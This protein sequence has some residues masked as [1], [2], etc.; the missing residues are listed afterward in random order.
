MTAQFS[1][2][3][4]KLINGIKK[5]IYLNQP[6]QITIN[7]LR[8]TFKSA[9]PYRM[10]EYSGSLASNS[11]QEEKIFT[12]SP[13]SA[14]EIIERVDKEEKVIISANDKSITFTGKKYTL[15]VDLLKNK[16]INYKIPD[17]FSLEIELEKEK[18]LGALDMFAKEKPYKNEYGE[19]ER[20]RLIPFDDVLLISTLSKESPFIDDEETRTFMMKIKTNYDYITNE[21][22]FSYLEIF[23]N[24]KFL[25]D[26]ITPISSDK[27]SMKFVN[28]YSPVIIT[29]ADDNNKNYLAVVMPM[30]PVF[31]AEKQLKLRETLNVRCEM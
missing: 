2:Q 11:F 31:D 20:V 18:L 5:T 12:I 17:T 23:F 19:F 27:I 8:A 26:A 21:E 22:F 24:D 6:I 9:D 30:S 16:P 15:T 10:A 13:Q 25:K 28:E 14:K 4:K 7:S 3:G 1:L 29:S